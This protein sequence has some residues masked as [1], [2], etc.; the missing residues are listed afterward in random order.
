MPA[1]KYDFTW[2]AK[3]KSIFTVVQLETVIKDSRN[4]YYTGES[5]M[6]DDLFDRLVDILEELDPN[7]KLVS[8]VE[9]EVLSKNKVTLPVWLGSMNKYKDDKSINSWLNKYKGN[10]SGDYLVTNKLDGLTC[11]LIINAKEGSIDIRMSKG[12]G[13]EGEDISAIVKH[14]NNIPVDAI[15]KKVATLQYKTQI[16]LLRGELVMSKVN[17]EKNFDK[18]KTDARNIISGALGAK[19]QTKAVITKLKMIDFVCFEVIDPNGMSPREQLQFALNYGFKVV[20]NAMI[21]KSKVN[22]VELSKYLMAQ[23]D[24]YEYKID[25]LVIYD[26]KVHIRPNIGNPKHAFAFKSR[27]SEDCAEVIVNSVEWQMSKDKY[28][29]PLV[30]FNGV[31]LGG[32]LISKATGKHAKFI[33]DNKIGPGA[34]IVIV[35]SGEVIPDIIEIIKPAKKTQMPDCKY[36]WDKT[37]TQVFAIDLTSSQSRDHDIKLFE[38]FFKKLE[39]KGVSKG[40]LTKIYDQGFTKL[41]DVIH[42][43]INDLL[44]VPTIKQKSAQKI[45]DAIYLRMQ[46]ISCLDLMVASNVFQRGFGSRKLELILDNLPNIEN[47]DKYVPTMTEMT[48]IKGIG[49]V[50]A[51]Q[52][53]DNL[54]SYRQFKKNNNIKCT[55]S[56][57]DNNDNN[58]DNDN[59]NDNDKQLIDLN[60][61]NVGN[62][63]SNNNNGKKTIT[64]VNGKMNKM[65]AK[66]I[67]SQKLLGQVV[68]FSGVRSKDLEKKITSMSGKVVGTISGKT[69]VLIIKDKENLTGKV[70]KAESQGVKIMTIDEF[71]KD[72]NIL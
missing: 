70:Q 11:L 55:T 14:I 25:G 15:K 26:D 41:K 39:I 43:T 19:T 65:M 40:I 44:T 62:S 69:T 34:K 56:D 57:D 6:D 10:S 38:H 32:A 42:I 37:H 35:R 60:N 17:F 29:S 45:Y 66:S 30:H 9:Y 28:L 59:D 2:F 51:D 47:D 54:L 33:E 7:N 48:G 16:L 21:P 12:K 72:F 67:Q 24:L 20:P 61:I 50:A 23:K 46:D 31:Y 68:V 22:T 71:Q 18:Q 1:P 27:M 53:L 3:N 63:S 4:A 13:N 58:N 8:S 64:I 49:K 5:L 52:F 36:E